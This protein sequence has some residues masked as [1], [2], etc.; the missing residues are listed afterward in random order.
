MTTYPGV[1]VLVMVVCYALIFHE[2]RESRKRVEGCGAS[3][4]SNLQKREINFSRMLCYIFVRYS[5]Q[6][7]PGPAGELDGDVPMHLLKL[8]KL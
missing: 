7:L 8:Y 4:V 3:A 2:M 6:E 5:C 1:P